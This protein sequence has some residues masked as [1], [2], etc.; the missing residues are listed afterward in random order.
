MYKTRLEKYKKLGLCLA[1]R[2]KYLEL[3]LNTACIQ[4]CMTLEKDI[5]GF[6]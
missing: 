6:S 4:K 3:P 1:V 2:T 5:S